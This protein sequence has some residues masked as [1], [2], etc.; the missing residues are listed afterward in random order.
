M[1]LLIF[2]CS[3]TINYYKYTQIQQIKNKKNIKALNSKYFQ[4]IF[5]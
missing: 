2:I 1:V 3:K 5:K 4:L